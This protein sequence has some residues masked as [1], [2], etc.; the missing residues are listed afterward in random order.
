[1]S[2]NKYT[3]QQFFDLIQRIEDGINKSNEQ[4]FVIHSR[5]ILEDLGIL[6]KK[7]IEILLK[8]L[9][10]IGNVFPE[11]AICDY[12]FDVIPFKESLHLLQLKFNDEVV[13]NEQQKQRV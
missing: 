7:G 6:N 10:D 4:E 5:L 3:K 8:F 2:Q 9:R 1:M 13:I 12:R 11:Q